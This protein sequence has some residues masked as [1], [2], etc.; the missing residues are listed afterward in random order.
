M[1]LKLKDNHQRAAQIT[2]AIIEGMKEQKKRHDL[3]IFCHLI[4]SYAENTLSP[5]KL[6]EFEDH[7]S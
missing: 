7:L 6:K 3:I 4:L 5:Q 1:Q 2:K